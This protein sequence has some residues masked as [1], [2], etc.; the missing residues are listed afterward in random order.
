MAYCEKWPNIYVLLVLYDI[1][2]CSKSMPAASFYQ[3]T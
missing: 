3:L 2:Y 1:K